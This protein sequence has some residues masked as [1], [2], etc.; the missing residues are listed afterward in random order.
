MPVLGARRRLRPLDPARQCQQRVAKLRR[1]RIGL[2][3][4]DRRLVSPLSA[5]IPP[6]NLMCPWFAIPSQ[7][8]RLGADVQQPCPFTRAMPV[9]RLP[10]LARPFPRPAAP[11]YSHRA[12]QAESGPCVRECRMLENTADT[13]HCGQRSG[14]AATIVARPVVLA[15]PALEVHIREIRPALARWVSNNRQGSIVGPRVPR[16]GPQFDARKRGVTTI[17]MHEQ[18]CYLHGRLHFCL[19][20]FERHQ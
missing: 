16:L 17:R 20:P 15:A 11:A 10:D 5:L 8:P 14:E 2:A 3:I 12:Q 4:A 13:A 9:G 1:R 19:R 6:A 18:R 7:L